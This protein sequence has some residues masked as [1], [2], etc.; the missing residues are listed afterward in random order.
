MSEPKHS[1]ESDHLQELRKV[2]HEETGRDVFYDVQF[3]LIPIPVVAEIR[4]L[5]P[6][7]EPGEPIP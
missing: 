2:Y 4:R 7:Q 3:G 1:M 6:K 5:Q